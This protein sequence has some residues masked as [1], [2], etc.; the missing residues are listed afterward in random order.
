MDFPVSETKTNLMRAFAGESQ[1]YMRYN[2][3]AATAEKAKLQVIGQVFRYTAD[4]EKE[5]A[6]I[7]YSHL[8]TLAGE[9]IVIDG[10][11]PVNL[12]DSIA[13]LLRMAEHGEFEEYNDVYKNFGD[14]AK[15]EGFAEIA[16]SFYMIADIEKTHCERFRRFAELMESGDLLGSQTEET[17]ICLN[18]GH[19]HK[20]TKTPPM[21]PVCKHDQGYFV[22]LG[23]SPFSC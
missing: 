13:E 21:C 16:A 19:I 15:K 2:F 5:H 8:R 18:C 22:R 3:A 6:E 12:S 23:S 20:G 7:F 14:T 11:Y 9:T 17:W 1:A 4:Q 10:G